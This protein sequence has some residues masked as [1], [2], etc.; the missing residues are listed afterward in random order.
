MPRFVEKITE[1]LHGEES[2]REPPYGPALDLGTGSAIWAVFLAKR[3]WQVTGVDNAEEPLRRGQDRVRDAGVDVR[4]VKGDVTDLRSAEIDSG[5]RLLL[6]TGTFHGLNAKQ[7]EAMGREVTAIAAPDAT[8]LLLA[9]QPKVRGPFPR[10]VTP[11]EIQEAFPGWS[12]TEV[13]ET[14]FEAPK[15]LRVDERWYRLH[16]E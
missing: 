14:G 9:W 6:D 1:L 12:V 8:V 7:R 2:G 10:G 11:G 4:L 16:R 15:P 13:G 3:G 5:F